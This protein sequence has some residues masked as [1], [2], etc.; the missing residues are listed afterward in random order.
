MKPQN[1]LMHNLR[2]LYGIF[3]IQFAQVERLTIS[4]LRF[5]KTPFIHILRGIWLAIWAWSVW[6][7]SFVHAAINRNKPKIFI[8]GSVMMIYLICW[9]LQGCLYYK[10]F[11]G[12]FLN[13][14]VCSMLFCLGS[15]YAIISLIAIERAKNKGEERC[16]SV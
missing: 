14:N 4:W 13:V 9:M 15:V 3:E 1:S 12:E 10:I 16:V 8:V 5:L 11:S 7:V 2:E 6:K